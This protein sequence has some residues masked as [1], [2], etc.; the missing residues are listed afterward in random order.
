MGEE[1]SFRRRRL[2]WI[3]AAFLAFLI[4][5]TLRS[6]GNLFAL[7]Y[8]WP[9]ARAEIVT[10]EAPPEARGPRGDGWRVAVC[11][12]LGALLL[13]CAFRPELLE[14][15]ALPGFVSF[16]ALAILLLVHTCRFAT[17]TDAGGQPSDR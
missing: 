4:P 12:F 2:I 14:Q 10:E 3:L 5:W 15:P 6:P 9:P 17:D 16:V 8:V 11:V 7:W 13:A 1:R